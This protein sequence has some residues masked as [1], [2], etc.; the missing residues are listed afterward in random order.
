[1]T[2]N[3]DRSLR[4]LCK[5]DAPVS[6]CS[7]LFRSLTVRHRP[8]QGK[9]NVYKVNLRHGVSRLRSGS[10]LTLGIIFHDAQ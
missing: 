4:K 10:R 2:S 6:Q 9:K 1:M 7:E 8:V 3:I 5:L